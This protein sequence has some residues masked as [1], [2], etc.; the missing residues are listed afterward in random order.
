MVSILAESPAGFGHVHHWKTSSWR[1][2]L[3]WQASF[4]LVDGVEP[5]EIPEQDRALFKPCADVTLRGAA[6]PVK[7]VAQTKVRFSF[8][9]RDGGFERELAVFGERR[10]KRGAPS[11]PQRFE[12]VPLSW[13][14]AFGGPD[15]A[16][17]PDGCGI[18]GD[19]LP[20]VEDP[21]ELVIS[22]SDRPRP[23]GFAPIGMHWPE[24][25]SRLGTYDG[26]WQRER[27]PFFPD[28]FDWRFFQVA[29]PPQQLETLAGDE[30]YRIEGMHRD[31]PVLA[32]RLPGVRMRAFAQ[33]TLAAGGD[34][35]EILLKLDTA[36]FDV[37]ALTVH[38]SW[39][40]VLEVGDARATELAQFFVIRDVM[41]A[42]PTELA[43]A[44]ERYMAMSG[45]Q[46]SIPSDGGSPARDSDT[47]SAALDPAVRRRARALMA[48]GTSLDGVELDG[49]DLSQLDLA[50]RS[51]VGAD[52]TGSSLRLC[53]FTDAD[54]SGA[55]LAGADLS[56]ATLDGAHLSMAD[57]AAAVLD[58][59]TLVGA[60]LSDADFRRV[61]A[62]R[63]RFDEASGNR[64]RF[65]GADLHGASFT[66]CKLD[67][68]DFWGA[69]LDDVDF[70]GAHVPAI[71]LYEVHAQRLSFRGATIEGA[72]ADECDLDS[73]D[74]VDALANES[75][76]DNSRLHA[77]NFSR[78]HLRGAGLC[79]VV[80]S[81]SVFAGVDL[82]HARLRHAA[83]ANADLRGA[84]LMEATLEGADLSGADL[85]GASLYGA[86][87][88]LATIADARFD[89][90]DL[91][92]TKLAGSQ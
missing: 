74:L 53:D 92:N 78:A 54:L 35:F 91:S 61:R 18:D 21:A 84:N 36:L 87:T 66:G 83:L 28:D 69:A 31:H 88:W 41:S 86:E 22:R 77:C 40:G 80:A 82:K 58:D 16:A 75:V 44:R 45:V 7:P 25:W 5:A 14:H 59:A 64:P 47:P 37:D 60:T 29:P 27:F 3:V 90:A 34:F 65:A 19:K 38:L 81:A 76:W 30:R 13:A 62:H 67:A 43:G 73:C 55:Q 70:S 49:G 46:P 26:A 33:Q 68:P 56:G 48:G 20:H 50:G 9:L 2:S 32:G 79:E 12:S 39:R 71:R 10:W 17:N 23:A 63:A 89:G 15:D 24:R 72:R 85:R 8:G 11:R 6:R 52:L 42:E 51:L 4:P 57:L 1:L